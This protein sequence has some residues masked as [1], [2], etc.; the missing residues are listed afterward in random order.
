MK[1]NMTSALTKSPMI[2]LLAMFCCLL[3]GSAFPCIKIGYALFHI[4]SD[5]VGSQ[6]LFAG[7]RFTLAGILVI[8]LGSIL[9][10]KILTPKKTS[11]PSILKL[12][13][14]QTV[15]QYLLFYIGLANTT[16]VKSSIITGSNVFLSILVAALIFKY[17]TLTFSKIAGCLLGFAGV[18]LINLNGTGLDAGMKLTGEGAV[19][20]SALSYA[21]SSAM[22]KKYSREESP[23]VLSGYQFLFGGIVLTLAGVAFGG[24]LSG[25]T[26]PSLGLLLYMAFISAAAYTLWGILLKYNP[27]AK[28]SVYGFLNPVFGVLLSAFL[29]QESSQ[30]FGLTGLAA[31]LLVCLGIFI[32]NRTPKSRKR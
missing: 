9:N 14:V 31:L 27:V 2:C 6:T 3:W 23:V 11:I 25:F 17:E 18:I 12:G 29:L 19:F 1:K 32:V 13:M 28:V 26:A 15:L 4:T 7:C 5:D 21:F 16:G 20:L 24:R 8:I 22:I 10:R 30:A